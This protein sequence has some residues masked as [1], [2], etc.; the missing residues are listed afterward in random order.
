MGLPNGTADLETSYPLS[1]NH[2]L[3]IA[4]LSPVESLKPDCQRGLQRKGRQSRLMRWSGTFSPVRF[5]RKILRLAPIC[6]DF[7]RNT[8]GFLCVADC[9]AEREGFEPS[10][11][12]LARITV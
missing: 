10:I 5:R 6:R 2:R 3:V 8:A 11:Q 4:L 9:V 1:P 7:R 12:V